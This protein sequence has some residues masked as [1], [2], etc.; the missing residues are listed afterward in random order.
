MSAF[1]IPLATIACSSCHWQYVTLCGYT[2]Q[3][4][5]LATH[6]QAAWLAASINLS[7]NQDLLKCPRGRI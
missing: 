7:C 3:A 1:V 2:N 4:S 6:L 5:L